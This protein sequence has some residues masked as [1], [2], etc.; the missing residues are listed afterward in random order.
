MRVYGWI[1]LERIQT[2]DC[3][4]TFTWYNNCVDKTKFGKA[5][6]HMND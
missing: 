4:D 1:I 2:T 6:S 5:F 3:G